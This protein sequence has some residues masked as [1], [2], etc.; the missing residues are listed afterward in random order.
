MGLVGVEVVCVLWVLV[1]M[2]IDTRGWMHLVL[3]AVPGNSSGRSGQ[4]TL[5][6]RYARLF[7]LKA[8]NKVAGGMRRF[9]AP[10]PEGTT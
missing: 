3:P 9:A 4:G 6:L 5:I 2:A 8:C 7:M 1:L 10:P